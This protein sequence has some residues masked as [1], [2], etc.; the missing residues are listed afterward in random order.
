MF[1]AAMGSR[2]PEVHADFRATL[3]FARSSD[4]EGC[5]WLR[6]IRAAA[7]TSHGSPGWAQGPFEVRVRQVA[8]QEKNQVSRR[9]RQRQAQIRREQRKC[10]VVPGVVVRVG[11]RSAVVIDQNC[12]RVV[13]MVAAAGLMH[14]CMVD[15][16]RQGDRLS[17]HEGQRG[18][19]LQHEQNHDK[20]STMHAEIV[21]NPARR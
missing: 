12:Q 9:F 20:P 15:L 13:V 21:A 17:R 16:R 19:Q 6:R 11:Q 18:Q 4:W 5:F 10:G 14:Q 7:G 3:R 2:Q 1:A 8:P